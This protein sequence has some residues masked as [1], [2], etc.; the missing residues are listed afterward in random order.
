MFDGQSGRRVK[1]SDEEV[2]VEFSPSLAAWSNA[3]D[4]S[5]FAFHQVAVSYLPAEGL[6]VGLAVTGIAYVLSSPVG[7]ALGLALTATLAFVERRRRRD[8]LTPTHI[9][10]Q[11]GLIWRRRF[12]LALAN[13]EW[14]KVV[15]PRFGDAFDAANIEVRYHG[16]LLLLPGIAGAYEK[17]ESIKAAVGAVR[18]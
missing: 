15:P 11:S 4:L 13:V 17:A 18:K 3:L 5:G 10:R 14:V 6:L 7:V 2:L 12:A 16:G 1:A 9:V 8:F